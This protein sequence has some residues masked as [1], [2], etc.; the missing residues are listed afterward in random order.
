M[1]YLI[2]GYNI[3]SKKEKNKYDEDKL[4]Y[5]IG[6]LLM[7]ASLILILPVILHFAF[8]SFEAKIFF[9]SWMAFIISTIAGVIYINISGCT[10]K[11]N[12]NEKI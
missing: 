6:N 10:R 8:F 7:I 11:G 1:T 12:K 5:Y 4:V 2:A 3:A 9:A